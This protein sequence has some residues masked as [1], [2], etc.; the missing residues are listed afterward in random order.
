MT[1]EGEIHL[2]KFLWGI[3]REEF[4]GV[5]QGKALHFQKKETVFVLMKGH[6]VYEKERNFHNSILS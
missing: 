3:S 2:E 1:H 5:D 4:I 6:V